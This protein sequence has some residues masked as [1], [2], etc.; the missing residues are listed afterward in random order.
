M[1][2]WPKIPP[3]IFGCIDF[4]LPSKISGNFVIDETETTEI[5]AF[6]KAFAVPP[7]A[8]IFIFFFFKNFPKETS[9]D[10]SETDKRA[11]KITDVQEL[12]DVMINQLAKLFSEK[13]S[14]TIH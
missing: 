11:V 6:F 10:L 1:S 13:D 2:L 4:I 3:A 9:P 8:I 12:G 5:P 14:K 7:V